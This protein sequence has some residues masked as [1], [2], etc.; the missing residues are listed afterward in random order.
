[1][2]KIFLKNGKGL[3]CLSNKKS[4]SYPIKE[5]PFHTADI[6]TNFLNMFSV[7]LEALFNPL[8]GKVSEMCQ[9]IMLIIITHFS[10]NFTSCIF[11]SHLLI[12]DQQLKYTEWSVWDR[13]NGSVDLKC[14]FE[15]V[16]ETILQAH[17]HE[18]R[19]GL[20]MFRAT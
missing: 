8:I 16:I 14:V 4:P 11:F 7:H 13:N 2:N 9:F 19:K 20:N 5:P 10:P 17:M 1:M 6:L 12:C 15:A 3:I 18:I